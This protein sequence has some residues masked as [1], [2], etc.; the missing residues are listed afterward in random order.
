MDLQVLREQIDQCD[1]T[2]SRAIVRRM[3][4]AL[5]LARYKKESGLPVKVAGHAEAVLDA[6]KAEKPQ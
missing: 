2:I 1:D 6:L 4:T 5:E 3:E